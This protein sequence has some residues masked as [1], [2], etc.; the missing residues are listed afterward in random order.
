MVKKRRREF[1]TNLIRHYYDVNNHVMMILKNVLMW[2]EIL[3]R[4]VPI[5][6]Q[7]AIIRK[8]DYER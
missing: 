3:S 1:S 2:S 7:P 4:N 6:L 5:A 8:W